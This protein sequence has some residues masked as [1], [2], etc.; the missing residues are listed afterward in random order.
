MNVARGDG[1]AMTGGSQGL[2]EG[3]RAIDGKLG[4][5]RGALFCTRGKIH[6]EQGMTLPSPNNSDRGPGPN[7]AG[8][9]S[10]ALM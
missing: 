5:K 9:A 6:N 2:S 7:W 8:T 10:R 4:Y 1:L 3:L